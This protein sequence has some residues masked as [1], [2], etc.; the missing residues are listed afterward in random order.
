MTTLV[1]GRGAPSGSTM[2]LLVHRL[3]G[4]IQ[5]TVVGYLAPFGRNFRFKTCFDGG[6]EPTVRGK[7]GRSWQGLQTSPPSS[8]VTSDRLP[9]VTIGLSLTIFTV[10]RLAAD[11]GSNG[12]TDGTGVAKGGAMRDAKVHRLPKACGS[13]RPL[14]RRISA[15]FAEKTSLAENP[16][17][18]NAASRKSAE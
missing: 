18:K 5:I 10:P 17:E 3:L 11:R 8:P 14:S 6:C 16:P 12:R 9:T 15:E 4:L 13:H 1:W 7:G 2:I